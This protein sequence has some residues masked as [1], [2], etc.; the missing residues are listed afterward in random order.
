MI[1]LKR[2][3][4]NWID[5]ENQ[6][7]V[8]AKIIANSEVLIDKTTYQE[9]NDFLALGNSL[10]EIDAS[11]SLDKVVF[12]PDL[13]KGSGIPVGTTAKFTNC[14]IPK[15]IGTDIGCGMQL[16]KLDVSPLVLQSDELDNRLRYRFFEG[17]RNIARS[18]LDRIKMFTSQVFETSYVPEEFLRSSAKSDTE[19]TRDDQL[20]SVG[21]GN[22][23]VE[24]QV[25]KEILDAEK[26][27]Q[28]GL[29][30]GDVVAMIHTGSV[31][32]GQYVGKHWQ[33]KAKNE[34]PT[35]I[36]K[37]LGG[38]HALYTPEL[39]KQYLD[40]QNAAAN[41]ANANR[42]ALR[43]MVIDS[44]ADIIG[45]KPTYKVIHDSFHNIALDQN[46][47]RKGACSAKKDEPVIVPGSMGDSSYLLCGHGNEHALCSAC[48]GAGRK[49]ARKGGRQYE[50]EIDSIRLVTK[51][52]PKK[53]HFRKDIISNYKKSL[54]EEAPSCYKDIGPAID[55][56]KGA[57]VATPVARFKPVL[58]IKGY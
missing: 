24:L 5:I 19:L 51:L 41:F 47:H 1:N 42:S 35:T 56:C 29:S 17:G 33:D 46:I 38:F 22:H 6:F 54:A 7:N 55:S 32:V 3:N 37:P 49:T 18:R 25:I 21:G 39:I 23:F 10:K 27:Y 34:W 14:I 57:D 40:A 20:G 16:V 53:K 43:D 45:E 11:I 26:A 8:D 36:K 15:A 58:T 30:K 4:D 50:D 31:S 13:H 12:S 52:D 9:I 28:W 2:I 44:I 48:H